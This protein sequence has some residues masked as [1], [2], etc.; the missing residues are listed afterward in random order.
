MHLL[1]PGLAVLSKITADRQQTTPAQHMHPPAGSLPG[2]AAAEPSGLTAP[3]QRKRRLCFWSSERQ[4]RSSRPASMGSFA[5][6]TL[7]LCPTPFGPP[8]C[9][10]RSPLRPHK[11]QLASMAHDVHSQPCRLPT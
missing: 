2:G 11:T 4:R 7:D 8:A 1:P 6:T 3:N 9:P 10:S 5:P